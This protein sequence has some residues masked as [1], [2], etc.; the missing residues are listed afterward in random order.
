VIRRSKQHYAESK[1]LAERE[2][3][4][5]MAEEVPPSRRTGSASIDL[6]TMCPTQTVGPLLQPHINTS[7]SSIL[8][9]LNGSKAVIENKAKCMVDVR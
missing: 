8:A 6:V 7:C 4:R 5:V 2:A 1:L 9:Y 3:W